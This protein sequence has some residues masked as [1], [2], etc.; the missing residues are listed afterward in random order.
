M[1]ENLFAF[2]A[3]VSVAHRATSR[4]LPQP[5]LVSVADY[6]EAHSI[7][8]EGQEPVASPS[9]PA[10]HNLDLRWLRGHTCSSATHENRA[11]AAE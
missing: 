11:V 4:S 9:P 5:R 6:A 3:A 2:G 10:R 8:T 7:E 1:R